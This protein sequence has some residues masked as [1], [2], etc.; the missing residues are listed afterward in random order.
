MLE[1]VVPQEGGNIG[2]HELLSLI[3]QLRCGLFKDCRGRGDGLAPPNSSG[4]RS[5]A[6][7]GINILQRN[8]EI[9]HYR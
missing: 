7:F 8:I 2:G 5:G 4:Q 6:S 9:K 3:S 1:P